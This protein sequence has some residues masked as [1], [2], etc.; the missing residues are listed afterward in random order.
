MK[1]TKALLSTGGALLIA[2][3]QSNQGDMNQKRLEEVKKYFDQQDSRAVPLSKVFTLNECIQ[4]AINNNLDLKLEKAKKDIS[5]ESYTSALLGMLPKMTGTYDV[6]RR[7]RYST[8]GSVA[9]YDD[10]ATNEV[11]NQY[12]TSSRKK[13]QT[14]KLEAAFSIVDFGMAYYNS[15][16][17]EDRVAFNDELVRR[18][19]QN[20]AYDISQ[21]YYEVAVSQTV[22]TEAQE[23]IRKNDEMEARLDQLSEEKTVAPMQAVSTGIDLLSVKQRLKDYRRNYNNS[24][25]RL[26]NLMGFTSTSAAELR[27]STDLLAAAPNLNLPDL[28]TIETLAL[29]NRPELFQSDL[30]AHIAVLETRKAIVSMFP[31]AQFTANWNKTD[32]PY[33]KNQYWHEIGLNAA[34]DFFSLPSKYYNYKIKALEE[35]MMDERTLNL[36]IGIISQ[37]HMAHGNIAESLERYELSDKIY[38]LGRKKL[39]LTKDKLN[40]EGAISTMTLLQTETQTHLYNIARLTDL[41][42]VHVAYSRLIN[43]VG[44][45]DLT[46]T[47]LSLSTNITSEE[48]TEETTEAEETEEESSFFGDIFSSSDEE[49]VEPVAEVVEEPVI[50]EATETENSQPWYDFWTLTPEEEAEKAREAAEEEAEK[51]REAEEEAREAAEEEAAEKAREVETESGTPWYDFWSSSSDAGKADVTTEDLE[52]EIASW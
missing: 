52:S 21:A 36:T 10:K 27:V 39:E 6:S 31:N 37:V 19:A 47:P 8:S 22:M 45:D 9:V 4:T 34:L 12:N 7:N 32:N 3:C 43:S 46:Q 28:K 30:N 50:E 23:L 15:K 26:A 13:T 41:S 20:L 11:V 25:I 38:E 2:G 51:A 16:Q 48:T 40:R 33:T 42:A 35:S 49:V 24:C 14:L 29:E 5:D 17:A 1:L 44:T 18:T